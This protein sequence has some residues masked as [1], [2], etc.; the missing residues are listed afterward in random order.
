MD[1]R[2]GA[3][4]DVDATAWD[5]LVADGDPF[6]SH[7]FLHIL[8]TG[9][10]TAPETGWQPFHVR[11]HE[12][13]RLV[14]AAPVFVKGH[15]HG[16]FVYDWHWAAAA[17]RSGRRYY[18]KLFVGP[19][20]TP[21]T[22]PRLLGDQPAELAALL[23]ELAAQ[24]GLSSVHV[25]CVQPDDLSVLGGAGFLERRLWQYHWTN[26]GYRDFEDFLD[27]LRRKKRKNIRQE[28]RRAEESGWSFERLRG[29]E[30]SPE[31]WQAMYRFHQRTFDDKGN[32]STLTPAVFEAWRQR[33]GPQTLLSVARNPAGELAAGALFFRSRSVLYGRY[34]G[35]TDDTPFIHFETCYY[36][37]IE[38]A[39]E[40][41]IE[42]IE[43]GA[44]GTHKIA[45]GFDP[46]VVSIAHWFADREVAQAV[47]RHLRSEAQRHAAEG[48]GLR[49]LSAYP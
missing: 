13:T 23:T 17:E 6:V 39:I 16:E 9:G 18:P 49:E 15:S 38:Y 7:A 41:G 8:E 40:H 44:Q 33:M 21:A 10:C 4:D 34:W 36:Q 12:G 37:A 27:A 14:A 35:T 46:A 11:C 45:R 47:A 1:V 31:L 43:P 25:A 5:E 30:A 48:E 26:R 24:N 19:P 32:W 20:F 22:G 28:R 3:I 2:L 29:D 42:R